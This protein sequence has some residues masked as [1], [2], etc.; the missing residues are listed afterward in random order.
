MY[1]TKCP[2]EQEEPTRY[3]VYL[4]SSNPSYWQFLE[5]T[6]LQFGKMKK[7][8]IDWNQIAPSIYKMEL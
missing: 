4:V 5:Q 2:R 3:S 7:R 1:Q 8:K 6:F